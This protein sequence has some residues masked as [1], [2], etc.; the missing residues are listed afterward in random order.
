MGEAGVLGL[1]LMLEYTRH[2]TP[3]ARG[4]LPRLGGCTTIIIRVYADVKEVYM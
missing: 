1:C 3:I 4:K 2:K